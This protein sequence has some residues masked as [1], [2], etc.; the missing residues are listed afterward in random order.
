[1]LVAEGNPSPMIVVN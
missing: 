1:M